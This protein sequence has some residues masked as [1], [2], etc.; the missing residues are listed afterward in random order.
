[1]PRLYTGTEDKL[2]LGTG[3]DHLPAGGAIETVGARTGVGGEPC[4]AMAVP[5]QH[6]ARLFEQRPADAASLVAG[7]DEQRPDRA[8]ARVGGREAQD[9]AVLLPQPDAT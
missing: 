3:A 4:R 5:A 2:A 1:M 6:V 7:R 8:V 9:G